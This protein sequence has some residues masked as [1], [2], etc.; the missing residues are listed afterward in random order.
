MTKG[1]LGLHFLR[2]RKATF[3]TE[4]MSEVLLICFELATDPN[5]TSVFFFLFSTSSSHESLFVDAK[6]EGRQSSKQ[7]SK[8]KHGVQ[9][10]LLMLLCQT[11]HTATI[12]V[13]PTSIYSKDSATEASNVTSCKPGTFAG[14]VFVNFAQV[15]TVSMASD[16]IHE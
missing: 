7:S 13:T 14:H 3:T 8:K 6:R 15:S 16:L 1:P 4:S 11:I 2:A 12:H 10:M 5:N 9:L